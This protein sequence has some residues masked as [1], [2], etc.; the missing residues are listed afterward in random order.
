MA[1]QP[2]F[3]ALGNFG[4]YHT[5]VF[6]M[7]EQ[8][9]GAPVHEALGEPLMQSVTQAVL[10]VSRL[11][12]PIGGVFKPVFAV[13]DKG[14]GP[15]L[16]DPITECIDVTFCIVAKPDLLGNPVC[17]DRSNSPQIGI[18]TGDDLAMSRR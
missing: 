2:H 9:T 5:F 7:A 14:P 3:A 16:L 8:H 13:G 17:L 15:D 6:Q 18:N 12:A 1:F 4:R 11:F 10:N